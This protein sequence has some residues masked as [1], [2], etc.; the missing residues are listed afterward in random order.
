MIQR[1]VEIGHTY[2]P[3]RLVPLSDARSAGEAKFQVTAQAARLQA[4]AGELGEQ[5]LRVAFVDDV[6]ARDKQRKSIA[7]GWR[8]QLFIGLSGE[9]V[10]AGTGAELVAFESAYEPRAR[11]MIDE[12][13]ASGLPTGYR[14]SQGGRQL[15][16]GTGKSK[17][18]IPL[19]GF[20]GIDDVTY[21]S[22]Q[23]LD[24][25]WLEHRLQLAPEAV[26]ILPVGYEE[27]QRQVSILAR[28]FPDLQ[29]TTVRSIFVER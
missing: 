10:R 27:Q 5:S 25:A 1:T 28:A 16:S 18:R 26:T 29:E 7:E 19:E 2:A 23:V 20:K 3:Q 11:Q 17:M 14:L 6:I 22:C 21:P 15:I 13:R 9:S 8:W 24:L 12:L 4:I